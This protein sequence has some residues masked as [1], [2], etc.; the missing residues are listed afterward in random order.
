[1]LVSQ[2]RAIEPPLPAREITTHRLNLEDCIRQVEQEATDK[3][4]G[5]L[6]PVE[7]EPVAE[8]DPIETAIAQSVEPVEP[9]PEPKVEMA[10]EPL[11]AAEPEAEPA[12]EP[13]PEPE[14]EIGGGEESDR[15]EEPVL[16]PATE[17]AQAFAVAEAPASPA[18]IEDIIA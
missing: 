2:L 13:E 11:E 10:D 4:L 16:K 18:S 15:F 5:R 1:A 17:P 14:P 8:Q 9:E 3:L 6:R 7:D 12:P